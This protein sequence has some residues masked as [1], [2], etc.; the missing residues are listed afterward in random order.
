MS[1]QKFY[2]TFGSE[3]QPYEGGW[4]EIMA[5]NFEEADMLFSKRYG[6]SEG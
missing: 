6:K 2:Y 5:A 4:V 1:K 3:G